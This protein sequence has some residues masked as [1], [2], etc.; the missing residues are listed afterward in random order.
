MTSTTRGHL[1]L[2]YSRPTCRRWYAKP[3]CS[4]QFL[5]L[6][7]LRV[8]SFGLSTVVA[9]SVAVTTLRTAKTYKRCVQS[10]LPTTGRCPL[11]PSV[12]VRVGT[13]GKRASSWL[14]STSSPARAFF[15][16]GQVFLG[17]GLLG[18]VAAQQA[19]SG[20]VGPHPQLL[21]ETQ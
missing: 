1:S 10:Q 3:S 15:K 11:T 14:S 19:V 18:L 13:I 8:A 16:T 20:A 2:G 12:A 5:L 9:C 6:P 7:V 4:R 17:R 21:A